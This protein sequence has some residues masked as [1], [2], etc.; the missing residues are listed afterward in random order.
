MS[1]TRTAALYG[2][3]SSPAA[4]LVADARFFASADFNDLTP[5]DTEAAAL[6]LQPDGPLR[7]VCDTYRN[8]TERIALLFFTIYSNNPW[9][10]AIEIFDRLGSYEEQPSNDWIFPV[11]DR[12]TI[13]R[14]QIVA[15]FVLVDF[16]IALRT[17]DNRR[18]WQWLD[19]EHGLGRAAV[20]ESGVQL[21]RFI[22]LLR[23][24]DPKDELLGVLAQ[25][26][27]EYVSRLAEEAVGKLR[28]RVRAATDGV[29]PLR[30]QQFEDL[31][32]E[33]FRLFNRAFAASNAFDRI[34]FD[35][36]YAASKHVNALRDQLRQ[37]RDTAAIV[38][39]D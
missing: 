3:D 11:L 24:E 10:R 6:I 26:E 36:E 14:W 7:R 15:Y 27:Y 2:V 29:E 20:A 22:E 30:R 4:H 8:Y 37:A 21:Q 5:P 17:G 9:H 34:G 28:A 16:R 35:D 32:D 38:A 12:P 31:K 23:V 39:V 13:S 19:A 33:A 18:L 25:I 1:F